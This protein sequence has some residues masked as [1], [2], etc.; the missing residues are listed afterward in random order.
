[1]SGVSWYRGMVLAALAAL[2]LAVLTGRASSTT[3]RVRALAPSC[4][5][6]QVAGAYRYHGQSLTQC[7]FSGLD[8]TGADFSNA[9]LTAVNF[10]RAK[11][12]GADFSG[13]TIV[14]SG[15]PVF[16]TDF[17]L[18]DLTGAKF[19]GA[20]FYA[21]TYF[22]Y[23][24][25][26]CADFSGTVLTGG[27]AIFGD[28]PLRFDPKA[29][30]PKFVGAKMNCEF[31][32][33]WPQLDLSQAD[34]SACRSLVLPGQDFSGAM[35]N[36]VTFDNLDLSN[37]R[38]AGAVLEH[39][40]FQGATLDHATGL[41]GTPQVPALLSAAKFN[42]A[43]LRNVDFSN[44]QLYGAN[45]TQADLTE[46]SFAG[47]FLTSDTSADPPIETAAVFDGAHLKN[48]NLA[49][50]HLESASFKYASLY[51]SFSGGTPSFPCRTDTAVCKPVT[52]YTCGCATAS[53]ATLTNTN[54]SNAFLY[55]VDFTGSKTTVNGT[56]FGSAILVG[57]SFAGATFSVNGGAPPELSNAVLSGAQFGTAAR[58]TGATMTGAF[59]D[60]GAATNQNLGNQL[61]VLLSAN[62]TRFRGWSG[63]AT[64]C[65]Q[66]LYGAFTSVPS[67]SVMTCP[68][69]LSAA[70]GASRPGPP[71]HG[72]RNWNGGI[73]I[74]SNTPVPG[75]YDYDA[76]YDTAADPS[77]VCNGQAVET[78]W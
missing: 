51:G 78:G 72:N 25:L 41:A 66:M 75:W 29:C 6:S 46:A 21:P 53:G 26:S 70:C 74:A 57:A 3:P 44:A 54:F 20:Q 61:T 23:A 9:T 65:V 11:L 16:P 42:K 67:S 2:A 76:T 55:G 49:G 32:A 39:A 14:D 19:V 40:S 60:F 13:A 28:S 38:W 10:V 64:P 1:M 34:I 8:L 62:Y 36:G 45:F 69:G 47:A 24:T 33:Q 7:N 52:G 4:P 30:R 68:N 59:L 71:P 5:A 17:T 37:T 63:S 43:S 58:L 18:A 73:P 31:Y 15:N 48:V 27:N 50:A 22:T 56:Q 77:A 12:G 35:L